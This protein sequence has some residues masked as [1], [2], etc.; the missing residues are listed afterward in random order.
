MQD[1][2]TPHWYNNFDGPVYWEGCP[3]VHY[4]IEHYGGEKFLKL[5]SGVRYSTFK[6]DAQQ[7]LGESW[8]KVEEDFWKWMETQVATIEKEKPVQETKSDD[9][10]SLIIAKFAE[11]V[12]KADWDEVVKG[13]KEANPDFN[14]LEMPKDLAFKIERFYVGQE[15]N[16]K[17]QS[18]E[19]RSK[20]EF[21]AVF[22]NGNFFIYENFHGQSDHFLKLSNE[23]F[24]NVERNKDGKIRGKVGD[25]RSLETKDAGNDMLQLFGGVDAHSRWTLG[26]LLQAF[27]EID[28]AIPEEL[29]RPDGQPL[30]TTWTLE[31]VSRPVDGKNGRWTIVYTIQVD[32]DK[33][34]LRGEVELDPAQRWWITHRTYETK[35]RSKADGTI[36]NVESTRE[37]QKL[38]D[39]LV[40]A[41][42]KETWTNPD[43]TI[44]LTKENQLKPLDDS[45]KQ[46][47]RNRVDQA[48]RA[49][50]PDTM[51]RFTK[52][53]LAILI[54]VPLLG[55]ILLRFSPRPVVS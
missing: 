26:L 23:G 18:V 32:G 12:N 5:Y 55:M 51:D 16:E 49:R 43:G 48:I 25:Y 44:A 52:T 17:Q 45:E 54:G 36:S 28:L 14:P 27:K 30:K 40:V 21:Q 6:S 15:K 3:L 47:L 8:E 20:N 50:E 37:Y 53:L 9:S 33:A 13:I 35:D 41:S 1:L 10:K 29:L 42:S 2:V 31:K 34:P 19:Q 24:A 7:I 38:N 39:Q 22:E 11:S 4:L 46:Q